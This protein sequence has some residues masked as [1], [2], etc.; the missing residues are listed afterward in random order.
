MKKFLIFDA[1]NY[2]FR[3]FYA[4]PP[5]N[6]SAG[7]PT[8]ALHFY[9]SMILS[10]IRKLTPDGVALAHDYKGMKFRNELYPEYKAQR[11]APPEALQLQFPWFRKITDAL[12]IRAYEAAGYEADDVIAALTSRARSD[13]Y[14]VI[15]ASS[16]KDLMQLVERTDDIDTV[17]LFD[18]MAK[19][20][21]A[22]AVTV[23]EVLERFQV[24]PDRVADVLALAGDTVDNIPG[25]KGVGEKT[26][27]KLIAQYGSLES[28]MAHLDEI[29]KPAQH[30][31]LVAFS[32]YAALSKKL[33]SLVSDIPLDIHYTSLD[34]DPQRVTRVFS[35][36]ELHRLLNDVLG[37]DA[38]PDAT[39]PRVTPDDVLAPLGDTAGVVEAVRAT[40]AASKKSAEHTADA[41][42]EAASDKPLSPARLLRDL[43][44]TRV[45][46]D[47]DALKEFLRHTEGQ[48]LAIAPLWLSETIPARKL[49][50]FAVAAANEAL[51]VPICHGRTLFGEPCASK[52][53][54]NLFTELL[55][56]GRTKAVYGLKP[57]FQYAF[58][59][60]LSLNFK[61]FIDTEIAA[62]LVHPERTALG[63]EVCSLEYLGYALQVTPDNWLGSGKKAV[64]PASF[65]PSSAAVFAGQ[66]AQLIL[67]LSE[68]LPDE[69]RAHGLEKPYDELDL[70][71]A[72]ILARM[73]FDGVAIDTDALHD[74]SRA[75]DDKI[76]ELDAQAHGFSSEDFNINSPK[77]LARFLFEVL[78]LVPSTKK[79]RQHGLSTDQE[80]LE[81]IDHPIA[82]IILEHRA[83]SKLRS[84]YSETLASLADPQ[85]HRIHGR[86]NACVTATTRLSSSDPNLQ[87]I[88]GRT[89]LG[90]QIKRAFVPAPGYTFI[91]ADYSQIELRLMAAFSKEP[92]LCQAYQNGEDVHAR[93]AASLFDL[94]IEQVT[95]PQRQ[96]AKT[97]NFGLLYGMGVQKLARE[98][99]YSK[100]EAKAFLEKFHAQFPTLSKFFAD[101][102]Q[103]ARDAGE[104]R[105]IFGHRRPVRELYSARP[106]L[107]AFG[108]RV[109]LNAPIQG[110][111]SDVVKRAMI[112]LDAAI[113]SHGLHARLLIQVHDELLLE[114]PDNEV[115][116]TSA[117]LVDAMENAAQIGVPL[118]V[119]LKTGKTWADMA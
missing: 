117:L 110:S 68:R 8:N 15:I 40:G 82:Q 56:S 7:F 35:S 31:N 66:W 46:Q 64:T 79:N 103:L 70:P 50:G 116:K 111:A 2:M 77:D 23:N 58:A 113:R 63:L 26:A 87:N 98:T 30:A 78:D 76:R 101:Q 16:D 106:M 41:L 22:K 112:R 5:M 14:Q 38:R 6:N 32:K 49:L 29:K 85:T 34:P 86:F 89:E 115:E 99:G 13:G 25:C 109:A 108:E 71:L 10:V 97:I 11:E 60:E 114:C 92:V 27:G 62:Y 33:T 1:S 24:T 69:L 83:V 45:C 47:D 118:K 37:P 84:T 100:A 36:L 88:P 96:L 73:E 75:F 107:R 4:S 17:Y 72:P 52:T 91:S 43:T 90:R 81:S 93:T 80:T 51:Y 9:T 95:K 55:V 102:V 104:T 119:E 65:S 94:P 12:G 59:H 20:G 28:L 61:S 21:K 42:P 48:T 74:L 44:D 105:T 19:G 54:E 67:Q 3:A 53:M 39:V 18:A 57:L